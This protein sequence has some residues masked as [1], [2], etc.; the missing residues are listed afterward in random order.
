VRLHGRSDRGHCERPSAAESG[1]AANDVQPGSD[2]IAT[3]LE[4]PQ[5]LR[6]TAGS[7]QVWNQAPARHPGI[8]VNVPN[9]TKPIGPT[10]LPINT[11]VAAD[12]LHS[13]TRQGADNDGS[14]AWR[15]LL[16][17][18]RIVCANTQ[19]AAIA[20]A[21]ASF[22]IRHT[23]GARAAIQEARNALKL[24]WRYVEA[25]QAEVAKLYA[26]P[27]DTEQVRDFAN[28]LLEVEAAGTQATAKH[29]KE[30]AAGIVKLW[31]SSP[32]NG[33]EPNLNA[34]NRLSTITTVKAGLREQDCIYQLAPPP[35]RSTA[36]RYSRSCRSSPGWHSPAL[37][38]QSVY[39]PT[40]HRTQR[41]IL[42]RIAKTHRPARP[43]PETGRPRATGRG[44]IP[45][46]P[47]PAHRAPA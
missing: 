31:T 27:M 12:L 23:G 34:Y 10:T 24:S 14:S 20:S 8:A 7:I 39:R 9:M 3:L 17:P 40:R 2:C 45:P 47:G 42:A 30:R 37:H 36:H 4:G 46:P 15:T 38:W 19:N 1:S 13:R 21:K 11:P 5:P 26:Q 44:I 32:T 43:L 16:T 18:V 29:R 6:P 22:A 33:N 28:A 41:Q 35:D 25:F